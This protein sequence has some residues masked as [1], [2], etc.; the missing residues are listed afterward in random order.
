[1]TY[2]QTT[3]W[4]AACRPGKGSGL[5]LAKWFL[6]AVTTQPTHFFS[7][8]ESSKPHLPQESH[9]SLI[10]PALQ[11]LVT[12]ASVGSRFLTCES[13]NLQPA[14]PPGGP[15]GFASPFGAI[16]GAGHIP[17]QLSLPLRPLSPHDR[18][19]LGEVSMMKGK[20]WRR[21]K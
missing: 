14:W 9:S 1:M 10:I 7:L 5:F 4:G 11:I 3:G 21:P 2:G 6:R 17:P 16:D 19:K 8:L 12:R 15:Q 18:M 13:P 20:V